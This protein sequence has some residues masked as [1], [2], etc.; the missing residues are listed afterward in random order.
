MGIVQIYAP[1]NVKPQ[2]EGVGHVVGSLTFSFKIIQI[3]H[4]WDMLFCF[5]Q[6][7]TLERDIQRYKSNKK[8][9]LKI[10]TGTR[11]SKSIS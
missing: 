6:V 4:P 2:G 10:I 9:E 11:T 1:I 7:A 5:G 3:P 8:R